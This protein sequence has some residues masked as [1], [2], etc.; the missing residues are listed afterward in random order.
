MSES[1][2]GKNEGPYLFYNE[3]LG[4]H[5]REFRSLYTKFDPS[6]TISMMHE[7]LARVHPT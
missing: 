6:E 5:G 3:T 1:Q 2:V 7:M 4:C